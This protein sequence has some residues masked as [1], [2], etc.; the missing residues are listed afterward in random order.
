MMELLT[1]S[2]SPRLRGMLTSA[3][4]VLFLIWL[5]ATALNICKA[6]HIDDAFHLEV[7]QWIQHNPTKP[8]SGSINWSWVSE[9]LK[10]F[11]QPPLYFYLIAGV[12]A[13]FGYTEVPM[14]IMQ[15]FFSLLCVIYGYK[16]FRL[17]N[18]QFALVGTALLVLS[19]AFLVNQNL[20]TD[21]P[22]LAVSLIFIYLLIKPTSQKEEVQ[23]MYV[24]AILVGT[25][26]L[27]K[28]TLLP[29]Y[30][31]LLISIWQRRERYSTLLAAAL[32]P[33]AFLVTWSLFNYIEFGGIHIF[34]RNVSSLSTERFYNHI[35]SFIVTLGAISPF[36]LLFA[37]YFLRREKLKTVGITIVCLAVTTLL[38]YLQQY[39]F[40]VA[41]VPSLLLWLVS[42]SNGLF[43]VF[44][45]AVVTQRL[46]VKENTAII[47][48]W[49]LGLGGFLVLFAPFMATR[50]V[51]LL[52]PSFLAVA[53]LIYQEISIP[54]RTFSL[55][56]TCLLGLALGISD[57]QYANF[58][59]EAASAAMQQIPPQHKVWTVGHWGWQWYSKQAGMQLLDSLDT[60]ISKGD[61]IVVPQ[62]IARRQPPKELQLTSIHVIR[63]E[64]NICNLLSTAG[65]AR[66]YSSHAHITP[67]YFASSSVDRV[68]IYRVD[69]SP[70]Q[71]R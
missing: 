23:N 69:N 1:V 6:F 4:L 2:G 3:Y 30:V 58:Y 10:Q 52:L 63:Y 31:I 11:N 48:F 37:G 21:I 59:R 55:T 32:I 15:S 33:I 49:G 57:W 68:T 16:L 38:L 14:H 46:T 50:H 71:K 35:V 67:W 39:G 43:A 40:R 42:C 27:I 13:V 65:H 47:V 53:G 34:N 70:Q 41:S 5:V 8:M 25:G 12:G 22:I 62:N 61:Y 19:P 7:A 66:F 26:L 29:L 36:T 17:F 44:S 56:A 45:A 60:Q 20:S 9:S 54:L 51:L 18:P 64:S 28:Y 24:A